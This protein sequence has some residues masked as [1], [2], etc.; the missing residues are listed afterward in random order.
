MFKLVV[1]SILQVLQKF[2]VYVDC[3]VAL[4]SHYLFFVSVEPKLLLANQKDVRLISLKN[5]NITDVVANKLG[6]AAACD[7][8]FDKSLVFWI[9]AADYKKVNLLFFILKKLIFGI[10]QLYNSKN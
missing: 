3:F 5:P 6:Q 8:I 2:Y 7:Y 1:D 9:D 10:I 4:V